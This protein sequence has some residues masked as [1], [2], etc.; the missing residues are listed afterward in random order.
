MPYSSVTIHRTLRLKQDTKNLRGFLNQLCG[1]LNLGFFSFEKSPKL[2]IE[3]PVKLSTSNIP[4]L[5]EHH[6]LFL[7]EVAVILK[8]QQHT[9]RFLYLH[10]SGSFCDF[11]EA[12]VR[13]QTPG[14]LLDFF[15]ATF[16]FINAI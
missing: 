10:H 1:N 12:E 9:Q 16:T 5:V 11:S 8:K 7:D 2:Q 6:S 15:Q 14:D 3:S 13:P 4:R